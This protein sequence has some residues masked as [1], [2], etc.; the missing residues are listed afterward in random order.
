MDIS[1]IKEEKIPEGIDLLSLIFERQT[2]VEKLFAN[3]EGVPEHLAFGKVDNL[4]LPEVCRH[5]NDNIIW[6]IV[7]EANEAVVALRNGKTWR[8]TKYFTDVHEYLDEVADIMIYFVNLC[9][10]SGIDPKQLTQIV[11]KK[12]KVNKD[13]IV[14]KY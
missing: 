3:I 6:R 9:L 10:A 11:L 13:R 5:I 8:K 14:T 1:E 12:I 4:N 7:Q 2:E